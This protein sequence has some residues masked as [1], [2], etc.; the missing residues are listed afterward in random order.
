MSASSNARWVAITQ[1]VKVGSQLV[2]MFVLTRLLTPS[3]YGL[4]AMAGVATN[5]AFILRDMGT[6]AAIIQKAELSQKE[7]SS[8]FWL[9]L[10]IGILLML[11]LWALAP[12]LSI[13]LSEGELTPILWTLALSFPIAASS[14]AHQALLERD[15][16]FKLIAAVESSASVL[17][18]GV[19]LMMAYS[20]YGV[21]SLVGQ[22]L[23]MTMITT[24]LLW[25]IS[26]WRPSLMVDAQALKSVF[27]FS[28]SMA[29]YQLTSYVFR[30]A[31]SLVIGRML[32]AGVLGIYSLAYKLML[33]PVQN[34]SW[35]AT[36]ALFPV[37]SRMQ[38]EKAGIFELCLK[39]LVFVSFVTAPL[40][41]GLS[42]SSEVFVNAAFGSQWRPMAELIMPLAFVGY[43]QVIVGVTGPVFMALGKTRLLFMLAIANAVVHLAAYMAGAQVAGAIGVAY[44]Y[45]IAS[46]LMAIPTFILCARSTKGSNA[47]FIAALAPSIIGGALVYLV[48]KLIGFYLD[49]QDSHHMLATMI[50]VGGLLYITYSWLFQKTALQ[51]VKSL[52][53]KRV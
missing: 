12:A 14:A 7:K 48:V 28:G 37:M 44:G 35:I 17:A 29:G 36:R 9:N 18:L 46:A 19:A 22:A 32:G 8:V 52:V 42:A 13:F 49:I 4:M 3:D 2:N 24:L 50:V 43:L 10:A 33:F 21:W 5:L 45:L 20:G 16:K 53:L 34:I 41:M 30:N 38:N 25:K 31:D 27:A 23:I 6:A 39:A 51:H 11:G 26:S 1:L 15:S 40:M 47:K